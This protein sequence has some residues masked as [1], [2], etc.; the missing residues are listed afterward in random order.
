[1]A[2]MARMQEEDE[3]LGTKSRSQMCELRRRGAAASGEGE[4]EKIAYPCGACL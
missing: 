1:M 4:S 3:M 2:A